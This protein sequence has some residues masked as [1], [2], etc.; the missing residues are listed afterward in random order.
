MSESVAFELFLLDGRNGSAIALGRHGNSTAIEHIS[1]D[2]DL[3]KLLAFGRKI[4]SGVKGDD[5][6]PSQAEVEQFGNEIFKYLFIETLDDLFKNVSGEKLR[7]QILSDHPKIR[8]VA[9]EYI[10][11]P[12]GQPVPNRKRSIVRIHPTCGIKRPAK[13]VGKIRVLFVTADPMDQ[14]PVPIYDLMKSMQ[15]IFEANAPGDVSITIVEGA[16]PKALATA[17]NR[18]SF[19]VFHFYGHGDVDKN[20]VASLVLRDSETKLS[21]LIDGKDLGVLL[22]G[23]DVQLAVLSACKSGAGNHNNEFDVVSTALIAAGVPAVLANQYPIDYKTIAPFVCE[24]YAELVSNGN[25]DE[26]VAN[27]RTRLYVDLAKASKSGSLDWGIPVLY[28]LSDAQQL[29]DK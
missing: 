2:E 24:V 29:F 12:S 1:L 13:S 20:G 27:G 23:K 6:P 8:E 25:I 9:W 14:N 26:A 11:T 4:E 5:K 22:A 21:T 18:T 28:R 17:I 3:E 19:D 7:L 10:V 15:R 16:S